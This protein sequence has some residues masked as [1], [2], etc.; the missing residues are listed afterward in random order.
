MVLKILFSEAV[1]RREQLLTFIKERICVF[2]QNNLAFNSE[3]VFNTLRVVSVLNKKAIADILKDFYTYV[4]N[5]EKKRGSG[6][7]IKLRRALEELQK[8]VNQ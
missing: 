4:E 7:D 2:V 3:R 8:I 5:V 6:K 1:P